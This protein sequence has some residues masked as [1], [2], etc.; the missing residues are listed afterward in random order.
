VNK[1]VTKD[2]ISKLA[3]PVLSVGLVV[4]EHDSVTADIATA[5]NVC[6]KLFNSHT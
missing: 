2:G 3:E 4:V 1:P 5:G 6:V